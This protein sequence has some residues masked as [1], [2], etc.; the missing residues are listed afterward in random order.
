MGPESFRD[1]TIVKCTDTFNNLSTYTVTRLG[2]TKTIHRYHYKKWPDG[3][4]IDVEQLKTLIADVT[5]HTQGAFEKPLWI[6]CYMGVGRTG[7]LI[8]GLSIKEKIEKGEITKGNLR[9]KLVDIIV[10]F[11]TERAHDFINAPEQINLLYDYASSLLDECTPA[12]ASSARLATR[13]STGGASDPS[14]FII[15]KGARGDCAPLSLLDQLQ[16][17]G[18]RKPDGRQYASQ[19]EL[20]SIV[21][22]YISDNLDQLASLDLTDTNTPYALFM[23]AL[24][25]SL[26]DMLGQMPAGIAKALSFDSGATLSVDQKKLLL[27]QYANLIIRDGF[28]FDK[29]AFHALSLALGK[30]IA[31]L[32]TDPH[33][34]K[35][36]YVEER[37][38]E[39]AI[40][41]EETLFIYY[42]G[43]V[44][45]G[46]NH[47]QSINL[48]SEHKEKLTS[49]IEEDLKKSWID[50][51]HN[52]QREKR[53]QDAIPLQS[54][55]KAM[56]H[57][58]EIASAVHRH[59]ADLALRNPDAYASLSS[60]VNQALGR[61]I[62]SDAPLA[63]DT[64]TAILEVS[65]NLEK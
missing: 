30:K 10:G 6:H 15:E 24:E 54:E 61:D 58:S 65:A 22:K 57:K 3:T 36:L 19:Q 42:N 64:I 13:S 38:P 16:Q 18:I 26:G 23:A 11:R 45:S 7:T 32:R 60:L 63:E 37:F 51:L 21:S 20:R 40:N 28:W 41:L 31:I 33:K 5:C 48:S 8:T 56:E 46:G 49:I 55:T 1:G 59:F 25:G 52:M 44:L 29:A 27:G 39:G 4:A 17:R 12:T 50:F 2:K 43:A 35:E 9:T 47:Y 53:K 14:S 34:S 62:T